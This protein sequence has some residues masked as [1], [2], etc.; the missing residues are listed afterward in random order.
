MS[1]TFSPFDNRPA[2]VDRLAYRF[3]AQEQFARGYAPLYARLF[4]I[5]A[6]WLRAPGREADP[7]VSWL[8]EAAAGRRS[9]PVTNLLLAGLHRRVL[10][11]EVDVAKLAAY[12]PTVGGQTSPGDGPLPG[13][14]REAI[15]HNQAEL[16]ALIQQA[17]VQTNETARGLAW[18]LPLCFV[19]WRVVQLVDLGASAGL[20]LVADRR[21]YGLVDTAGQ[22]TTLNAALRPVQFQ[23]RITGDIAPLAQVSRLPIITGR[24]GADIHPFRLETPADELTLRAFIWADQPQ[25]LLRLDEGIAA[26]RKIQAGAVPVRLAAV[27]LPAELPAFLR[28]LAGTDPVMIYNTYMTVY[29]PDRGKSLRQII[30]EWAATQPRPVLW[31]Q[32]EPARNEDP[33]QTGWCAWTLDCWQRGEHRR[34]HLGWV[35]PHGTEAMFAPGFTAMAEYLQNV[36]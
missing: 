1:P 7:L 34:W 12:Y 21:R 8:V 2:T 6:G 9:L 20:N 17:T 33:P 10:A 23:T 15:Q 25:R 36:C 14:L 13:L 32:W 19:S 35:H 27:N 28:P 26:F 4:G 18:V 31:A 29:L 3:A 16:G 5:L 11:G 22:L 30:G 24:A